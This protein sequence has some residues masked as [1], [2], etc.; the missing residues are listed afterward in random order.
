[1]ADLTPDQQQAIDALSALADPARRARQAM[2]E[3]TDAE[4]K[5]KYGIEKFTEGARL[6]A[7]AVSQLARAAAATASQLYNGQKGAGAFNGALDG[8]SSAAQT[9]SKAIATMF[10]AAKGAAI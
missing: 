10:P 8:M 6:S 7:T 5:A 9:S 4:M 1:M 3:R 2:E